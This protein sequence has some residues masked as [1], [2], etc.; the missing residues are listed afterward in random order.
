M[1]FFKKTISFKTET[2]DWLLFKKNSRKY[3]SLS[4]NTPT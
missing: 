1:N 2:N 4:I 3:N